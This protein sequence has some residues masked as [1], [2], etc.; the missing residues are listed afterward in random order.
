MRGGAARSALV[1]EHDAVAGGIE[2]AAVPGLAAGARP[3]VQKDHGQPVRVA[4]GLP[5]QAVTV[6]DIE[7][8]GRAG[9]NGWVER[10][11][12]H[13]FGLE[14]WWQCRQKPVRKS[15][16]RGSSAT[17]PGIPECHGPPMETSRIF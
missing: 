12:H 4:A 9:L 6:A 17:D 11:H 15:R 14:Y 2:E 5:V 8:A 13:A 1:E 16:G 3:A 7:G 10:F